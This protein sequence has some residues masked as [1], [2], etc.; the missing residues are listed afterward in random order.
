MF[1][2]QN[3]KVAVKWKYQIRSGHFRTNHLEASF[4]V[5]ESLQSVLATQYYLLSVYS[6]SI[7]ST[8]NTIRD[9]EME[10]STSPSE[11]R[12]DMGGWACTNS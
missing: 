2:D 6:Y 10:K 12:T 9:Y 11:L 4:K 8:P 3:E 5:G 1:Y 7:P